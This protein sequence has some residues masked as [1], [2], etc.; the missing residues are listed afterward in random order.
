MKKQQDT[1]EVTLVKAHTHAGV[2]Y[3]KGDKIKVR[4][5]QKTW[6]AANQ[7]ITTEE[8]K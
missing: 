5:S 2:A 6:L 7:V 3:A 8:S 4:P 1:V